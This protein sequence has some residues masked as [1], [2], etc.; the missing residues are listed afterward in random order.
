MTGILNRVTAWSIY[1]KIEEE[2]RTATSSGQLGYNEGLNESEIIQRY[3]EGKSE[4]YF[5]KNIMPYIEN[6][7]KSGRKLTKFIDTRNARDI[8]L[9]QYKG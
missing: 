7:R 1:Q 8:T 2:L 6:Y 4:T 5:K 9:W 3:R